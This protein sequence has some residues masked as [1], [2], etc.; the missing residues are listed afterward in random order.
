MR[1]LTPSDAYF[2]EQMLKYNEARDLNSAD[3]AGAARHLVDAESSNSYS[4]DR[5]RANHYSK[6]LVRSDLSEAERAAYRLAAGYLY[7]QLAQAQRRQVDE[8][9]AQSY[10][11]LF[12]N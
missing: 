6:L 3:V 1:F 7:S 5:E 12:G 4:A 10:K 11:S 2:S 8:K 9:V